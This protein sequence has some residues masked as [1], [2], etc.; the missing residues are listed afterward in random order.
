MAKVQLKSNIFLLKDFNFLGNLFFGMSKNLFS[1]VISMSYEL[2]NLFLK[3][4]II[5]PKSKI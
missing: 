2:Q 3:G 5:S 4:Q 1:K